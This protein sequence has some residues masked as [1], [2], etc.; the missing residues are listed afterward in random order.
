MS[1]YTGTLNVPKI[2]LRRYIKKGDK[3][4]YVGQWQAFLN[5]YVGK[6]V[7][8]VDNI[9]GDITYKYTIQFQTEI[10]GKKEA[11]GKV[12]KATI[13]KAKA[14]N[15]VNVKQKYKGKLPNINI[16]S[17]NNNECID[18]V[19]AFAQKIAN[20]NS[21]KY[22][23]WTSNVKTHKCGYCHPESGKGWNCI[24][25]VGSCLHDGGKIP[26]KCTCNGILSGSE[27]YSKCT[28][29]YWKKRNGSDWKELTSPQKGCVI[30]CFDKKTEKYK[31]TAL[32][33]GINK[34][35]D[36]TS[37]NGISI[38]N[39]TLPSYKKRYFIYTG[40]QKSVTTATPLTRGMNNI[41]VGN[42]QDFL[43]WWSNG[44]FYKKC[45]NRDNIFGNNTQIWTAKFQEQELGR[46]KGTGIVDTI[47]I[48]KAKEIEK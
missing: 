44:E 17:T 31:H 38:R 4:K 13:V 36:A 22:K 30:I 42:W 18:K 45:G 9:Y 33:I 1:K 23:K 47:T 3:N 19:C 20:D 32:A 26:V 46:G 2:K 10:F 11:D 8:T 43:N 25:Y 41:E 21:Y 14:Y 35:A 37:S 12:G 6:Q 24:G 16:I 40:Q 29:A 34:I 39:T 27:T 28:I 5:W 15:K 48:N 7:C